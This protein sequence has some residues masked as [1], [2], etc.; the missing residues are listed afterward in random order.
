[1]DLK[2]NDVGYPNIMLQKVRR[3]CNGLNKILPELTQQ[4]EDGK[5]GLI[6]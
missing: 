5:E 2:I 3:R 4:A 1:M 6:Q